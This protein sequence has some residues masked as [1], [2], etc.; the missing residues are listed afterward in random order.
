[1]SSRKPSNAPRIGQLAFEP[2][3]QQLRGSAPTSP[4]ISACGKYTC[5]TVAGVAADMDHLRP[6][7]AHDEGR[8]LDG[9]VADRDDEIGL[10]DRLVDLVALRQRG[11]AHIEIG[12]G[13]DR[14][15]AHLGVEERNPAVGART[16]TAARRAAGGSPRRPA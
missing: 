16:P 1:M 14:A 10:V 2:I 9:V 5:S 6:V 12:A 3:G 13:V 7:V 8:L 11:G 4:T 15:L